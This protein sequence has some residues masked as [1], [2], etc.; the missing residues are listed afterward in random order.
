MKGGFQN[1][2]WQGIS[3]LETV[4]ALRRWTPWI[5]KFC[6]SRHLTLS[7]D[8]KDRGMVTVSKGVPQGSPLSPVLFLAYIA[9]MVRELER[10]LSMDLGTRVEVISYMDDVAVVACDTRGN[11]EVVKQLTESTVHALA[12]KHGVEIA[13]EKTEWIVSTSLIGSKK[14]IKWL[15]VTVG[16]SGA[17]IMYMRDR[18]TKAWAALRTTNSIGN[19]AKGISSRS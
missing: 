15:G 2:K 6:T 19:A 7:W 4:E 12:R 17:E 13:P 5:R 9:P 1:V 14:T 8:G 3:H 18:V 16:W 10:D 11:H